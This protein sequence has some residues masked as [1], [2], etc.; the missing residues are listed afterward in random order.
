MTFLMLPLYV[1]MINI[2]EWIKLFYLLLVSAKVTVKVL[3]IISLKQN[4][5]TKKDFL[6]KGNSVKYKDAKR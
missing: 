2:E 5:Q 6:R 1:K 3:T 4:T